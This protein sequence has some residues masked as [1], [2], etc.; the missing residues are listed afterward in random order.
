[1]ISYDIFS[2]IVNKELETKK[3]PEF[4]LTVA[5]ELLGQSQ[6]RAQSLAVELAWFFDLA[7]KNLEESI[8]A[9]SSF[10]EENSLIVL[11]QIS[12]QTAEH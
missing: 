1:M 7:I 2:Y 9:L 12:Q 10:L 4:W 3:G 6:E 5:K 11:Q 8:I